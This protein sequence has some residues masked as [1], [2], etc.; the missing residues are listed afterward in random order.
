MTTTPSASPLTLT[1][2][3]TLISIFLSDDQGNKYQRTTSGQWSHLMPGDVW[4]EISDPGQRFEN[5][6]QLAMD[7]DPNNA[8]APTVDQDPNSVANFGLCTTL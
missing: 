3:K 5:A 2:D 1:I 7:N 8:P 4:T 6:Y